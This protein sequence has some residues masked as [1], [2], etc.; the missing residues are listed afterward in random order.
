MNWFCWFVTFS[1]SRLLLVTAYYSFGNDKLLL[2][3]LTL[4]IEKR[5]LNCFYTGAGFLFVCLFVCLFCFVFCFYFIFFLV[6]CCCFLF[7]FVLFCFSFSF[8]F[9]FCFCFCLFVCFLL[10]FLSWY[11]EHR[12]RRLQNFVQQTGIVRFYFFFFLYGVKIWIASFW[13]TQ[14]KWCR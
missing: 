10:M 13:D 9:V 6:F 4:I 5:P 2:K 11:L 7:V 12:S 14:Y 3:T 1:Y 8:C